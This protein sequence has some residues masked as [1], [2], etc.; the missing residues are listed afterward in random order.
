MVEQGAR[1][2]SLQK[3]V[4]RLTLW[5]DAAFIANRITDEERAI[6]ANE[7]ADR[8]QEEQTMNVG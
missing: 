6:K 7:L 5:F 4:K 1:I 2:E 3:E 8:I